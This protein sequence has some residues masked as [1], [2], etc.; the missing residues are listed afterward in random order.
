MVRSP[1][2]RLIAALSTLCAV[3]TACDQRHTVAPGVGSERFFVSISPERDS[4]AVGTTLGLTATVVDIRGAA[5]SDQV[6][7][8]SSLAPSVA[9]VD[10]VGL[11]T[12]VAAGTASV[13]AMVGADEHVHAD[14]AVML[15]QHRTPVLSIA[16]ELAEITLGDSLRLAV[17]V[18]TSA[19]AEVRGLSVRWS[20]SDQTIVLISQDGVVTS[21]SPGDAT[22][23][24][25]VNGMTATA[26]VRV[27]PNP[28]YS[29]TVSPANSGL[30]PGEVS[31]LVPSVRDGRGRL[32][33]AS[34]V[35]W[36]SSAPG[37][38]AVT[39]DGVVH[40][41][42]KGSAIITATVGAKRAS[43]TVIVHATPA[44]SVSV[45]APATRVTTGGRLKAVAISRDAAGSVLSGRPVAWSSSN[46]AVAQVDAGGTITGL[47][48]GSTSI[49]AIV[50]SKIGTLPI[51]VISAITTTI[52]ILPTIAV[53]SLGKTAQLMAEVRDQGGNVVSSTTVGWAS[54]NPS[55]ATVTSD[56]L[57]TAVG[58][59]TADIRA[60]AGTVTA[61]ATITVISASIASVSV[62]PSA[63]QIQTGGTQ[64][65]SALVMANSG[66]TIPN[67][68]VSW[69]S[70][71]PAVATVSTSG[72]VI[73]VSAGS[74]T[75]TATSSG[76]SSSAS[77]LV[78]SPPPAAVV[79]VAVSLNS[80]A[81]VVGQS[82]QAVAV[83]RD[84]SGKAIGGR[85]VV[86]SSDNPLIASVS[87]VG[88]VTA[89]A[90]GSATI[91]AT[92][93]GMIG[94][95][96]ISIGAPTML[97]VHSVQLTLTPSTID[98]GNAA[99]SKV[100][101]RDSLGAIL[102][103]RTV[104]WQSSRPSV[105]SVKF[106]GVI[107]G[108]SAGSALITAT[109]EGKSATASITVRPSAI[110]S[111]AT[112]NVAANTVRLT[113]GQST[114]ATATAR[115][116]AGNVVA[117]SIVTW[118][119]SHPAVA[120]VSTTGLVTG[121][122]PGSSTITAT[123]G[124]KSGS[125]VITVVNLPAAASVTIPASIDASG[126]DDV[127]AQLQAWLNS[128]PDNSR[129]VG[130]AGARY[131]VEF[132]LEV[133][134]RR[135]FYFDAE[136]PKQP[137]ML[138]QTQLE[139][140]GAGHRNNRNREVL[141]FRYGGGHTL[142][143]WILKGAQPNSGQNGQFIAALEAQ[144]GVQI[145]AVNGLLIEDV[146]ISEVAGDFIYVS[147][148]IQQGISTNSRDITIRRV[149]GRKSSRQGVSV[150]SGV[151]VLV[152]NSDFQDI[153][154]SAFDIE[155]PGAS[156]A[157]QYL[158]IRNNV[159][160]GFRNAWIAGEGSA[161]ATV[162]HIAIENNEVIGRAL[163]LSI[164]GWR[165]YSGESPRLRRGHVRVANNRAHSLGYQ[166]T[167]GT[168]FVMEFTAIDSVEVIGNTVEF[169]G[170]KPLSIGVWFNESCGIVYA[171]NAWGNAQF[172]HRVTVGYDVDRTP[173]SVVDGPNLEWPFCAK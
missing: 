66:N 20:T 92:I 165:T 59:G 69:S 71:D 65:L 124:G 139:P 107:T 75:M 122:A 125:V 97:P 89:T 143:N 138:F 13:V 74:A 129:I 22:L 80:P 160:A 157:I 40:A 37:I 98:V 135:A 161:G 162:D 18:R 64:Q 172:D 73:G 96:T 91:K 169:S 117:G 95:A 43:A 115:D 4:I 99:T 101:L 121:I 136:N 49:H 173:I 127:S 14:T 88:L 26:L 94:I 128:L 15:V 68:A 30:Y 9:T 41:S 1:M 145:G 167:G 120:A 39:L 11:V 168:W 51:S 156:S 17:T 146:F 16:P 27:L 19:G 81:L 24:A 29:I 166:P 93:D 83:A 151:N 56:G 119:S 58:V 163:M 46:P 154:R 109:S 52:D 113:P 134:N 5:R 171:R 35:Q 142:R 72:L 53:V 54:A 79:T 130:P 47:V 132:G 148:N 112:V 137:P 63:S 133:T 70:S 158:T 108:V 140:Y 10:A 85:T 42:A 36:S 102:L 150:V 100:V 170:E 48:V 90:A 103:G 118:Q 33:P 86:W 34:D 131:R 62:T 144:H 21:L 164:R 57:A 25:T 123:A 110:L 28:I 149:T 87:A 2:V 44:A 8:W 61:H 147:N 38:A 104:G 55:V 126:K 159:F 6:V 152:E 76:I 60:T 23:T 153:R 77:V 12:G 111:V 67:A 106:G 45:T 116:S 155:P 114:Q 82:T 105:V 3:L 78:S 32:L 84:A 7:R 141:T 50:D 31:Q